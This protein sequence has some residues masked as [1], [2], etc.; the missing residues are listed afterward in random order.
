[1][2]ILVPEPSAIVIEK[3]GFMRIFLKK[4]RVEQSNSQIRPVFIS[5]FGQVF[6]KSRFGGYLCEKKQGFKGCQKWDGCL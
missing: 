3:Q 6:G 1:M 2:E 5:E 4:I